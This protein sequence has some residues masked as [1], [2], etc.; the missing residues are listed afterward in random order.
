[1]MTKILDSFNRVEISRSALLHNLDLLADK[2]GLMQMP[3]IKS[4]AYGHGLEQVAEIL[5]ERQIPYVAVNDLTETARVQKISNLSVLV[6]GAVETKNLKNINCEKVAIMVQ[7]RQTLSEIAELNLPPKVHLD[8]DTGMRRYGIDP[9][10]LDE[11]LDLIETLPNIELEGVASHLADG[12]SVE[13]DYTDKQVE[14]FDEQVDKIIKRGFKPKF[15]HIANAP[16]FAKVKSKHANTMR[17]GIGIYGINPLRENDPKHD[18]M[19]GVQP[20]LRLVSKITKVR[21]LEAGDSVSYNHTFT[22][23]KEMKIGV[24][25]VGYYEGLP[26]SLSNEGHLKYGNDFLPIVG[27]ICMNHT[28]IDISGRDIDVGDEITVISP[29]KLDSNSIEQLS[30]DY[31]FFSYG[32]LVKLSSSMERIIVD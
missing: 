28:I 17:P 8:I 24:I 9:A 12:D 10:E 20:V 19:S 32:L 31:Y 4:N 29:N 30:K 21:E 25:P 6:M 13:T 16:G 18:V 26:R 23:E 2:S 27:R 5:K 15:I 1:M 7:D 11:Y 14:L 22:A 3:V